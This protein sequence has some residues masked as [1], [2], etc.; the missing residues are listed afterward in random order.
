MGIFIGDSIY[1]DGV[2][3]GG[4]G[5]EQNISIDGQKYEFVKIGNL[6]WTVRNLDFLP[7]GITKDNNISYTADPK[8]GYY[9][10]DE[11]LKSDGLLYNFF[12][13][14]YIEQNNLLPDGWRIPTI[15]DLNNLSNFLEGKSFGLKSYYGWENNGNGDNSTGFNAF[16]CGFSS[17]PSQWMDK[18]KYFACGTSSLYGSYNF[19]LMILSYNSNNINI[20]SINQSSR[21]SLRL[22][23]NA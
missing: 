13:I 21:V 15:S 22:C 20:T 7:N 12:A 17:A 9:N 23:K 5:D 19:S 14:N 4:G 10:G 16:P 8:A 11:N 18:S 3:G 6:L 1:I 2:G